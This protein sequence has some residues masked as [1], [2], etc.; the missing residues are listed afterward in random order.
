MYKKAPEP[1]KTYAW[2]NMCSVRLEL[3]FEIQSNLELFGFRC[4]CFLIELSGLSF[5]LC[6]FQFILTII[7][8][9]NTFSLNFGP[10]FKKNNGN[11]SLSVH[12]S[13]AHMR[14]MTYFVCKFS[15]SWTSICL[16]GSGAFW[17]NQVLFRTCWKYTFKKISVKFFFILFFIQRTEYVITL[18][19]WLHAQLPIFLWYVCC[20]NWTNV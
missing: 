11:S 20:Y 4:Y 2:G 9:H 6:P 19:C 16:L 12:I 17:S 8:T 1:N 18:F 7:H 5:L 10:I 14:V 13:I 3:I 15:V